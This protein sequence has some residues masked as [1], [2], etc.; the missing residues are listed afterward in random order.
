MIYNMIMQLKE[1]LKKINN[2]KIMLWINKKYAVILC[3]II[4]FVLISFPVTTEVDN[5]ITYYHS[6]IDFGFADYGF[7]SAIIV[8]LLGFLATI[9]TNDKNLK[10]T[11]L[12]L[13]PEKTLFVKTELENLLINYYTDQKFHPPDQILF[14]IKILNIKSEYDVIFKLLAPNSYNRF[15]YLFFEFYEDYEEQDTIPQHN[16]KYI[17]GGILWSIFN[18]WYHVEEDGQVINYGDNEP[19]S[20][21]GAKIRCKNKFQHPINDAMPLTNL[22]ECND[23]CELESNVED[24]VEYLMNTQNIIDY[25]N[26][27][28]QNKTKELTL[29]KIEKI[30]VILD[31]LFKD[32]DKE[33]SVFEI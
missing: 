15:R 25:I 21:I 30:R 26:T 29:E 8:G 16:S 7:S 18:E 12:S 14:L 2:K 27:L 6:V 24:D 3:L 32:L 13:I 23:D 19:L 33:L 10:V 17:I 11:K 20:Y 31:N 1:Y 4:F 28:P 5:N 9:Y 22:S